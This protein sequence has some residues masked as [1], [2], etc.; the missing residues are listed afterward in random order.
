MFTTHIHTYTHIWSISHIPSFMKHVPMEL[1]PSRRNFHMLFSLLITRSS[2]PSS[3]LPSPFPFSILCP[4]LYTLPFL[5]F[6]TPA[7]FSLFHLSLV[8]SPLLSHSSPSPPL[9]SPPLPSPPLPSQHALHLFDTRHHYHKAACQYVVSLNAMQIQKGTEVLEKMVCM[10]ESEGYIQ[11][12][13]SALL[14]LGYYAHSMLLG[15]PTSAAV[16]CMSE[17][18]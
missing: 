9:P 3:P 2:F 4:L 7:L 12:A 18:Q 15:Q 17:A 6:L 5:P 11:S 1:T 14:C 8:M 10:T 13:R 16:P